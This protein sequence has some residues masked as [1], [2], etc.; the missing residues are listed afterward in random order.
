MTIFGNLVIH[1][2]R[3]NGHFPGKQ[4][5]AGCRL[6]KNNIL[7]GSVG[8]GSSSHGSPSR[9]FWQGQVGSRVSVTDPVSEPVW[10]GIVAFNVPLDTV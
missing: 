2:Y 6:K 10:Y 7:W 5:L 1:T 8:T 4:R 9:R 3:F